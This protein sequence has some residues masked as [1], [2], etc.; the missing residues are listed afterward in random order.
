MKKED[1]V[2][3][4]QNGS[5][6]ILKLIIDNENF[7]KNVNLINILDIKISINSESKKVIETL[8]WL[9]KEKYILLESIAERSILLKDVFLF[10]LCIDNGYSLESSFMTLLYLA[11]I[12]NYELFKTFSLKFPLTP[13][14]YYWAF[15]G[16]CQDIL[17]FLFLQKVIF[18]EPSKMWK[19]LTLVGS[20]SDYNLLKLFFQNV[21]NTKP[22]LTMAI[23]NATAFGME[24]QDK[25]K[26]FLSLKLLY[27]NNCPYDENS[28]TNYLYQFKND[29]LDRE[30]ILWFK[31]KNIPISKYCINAISDEKQKE[32]IKFII[33]KE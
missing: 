16:Q 8:N 5:L 25:T 17:E 22:Y 15:Y 23:F 6:N 7:T 3:C 33:K 19:I 10:E 18:P 1:F 30:I 26:L 24:S 29:K 11:K 4:I 27:D 20:R 32:I 31:H 14:I 2:I 13:E 12:G 21:S 28:F 9:L